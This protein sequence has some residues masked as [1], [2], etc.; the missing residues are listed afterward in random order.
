M[1]RVMLPCVVRMFGHAPPAPVGPCHLAVLQPAAWA[2]LSHL[3]GGGVG[4]GGNRIQCEEAGG[5]TQLGGLRPPHCRHLGAGQ[6]LR[7]PKHAICGRS[8]ANGVVAV[9]GQR[10]HRRALC[11]RPDS[12]VTVGVMQA[13]FCAFALACCLFRPLAQQLPHVPTPGQGLAGVAGGW[14][15]GRACPW[16]SKLG[17]AAGRR[18]WMAPACLAPATWCGHAC[19]H[20]ARLQP[21][22]SARPA[23]PALPRVALALLL[24]LHRPSSEAEAAGSWVPPA[25]PSRV[26]PTATGG[27]EAW[28]ELLHLAQ[29]HDAAVGAAPAAALYSAAAAAG[30]AAGRRLGAAEGGRWFR[31]S[32]DVGVTRCQHKASPGWRGRVGGVWLPGPGALAQR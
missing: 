4:W 20:A 28:E 26:L 16:W 25:P 19:R 23:L 9:V 13:T 8:V 27:H 1:Q 10:R 6:P 21:A 18:A 24:L 14:G 29:A 32:D 31:S 22:T 15:A 12:K 5:P 3:G 2:R 7:T 11:R 30:E 17:Q